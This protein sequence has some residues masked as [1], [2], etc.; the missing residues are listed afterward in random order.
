MMAMRTP[1]VGFEEVAGLQ[2]ETVLNRKLVQRMGER[3]AFRYYRCRLGQKP[4][5]PLGSCKRLKTLEGN[6]HSRG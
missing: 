6:G 3:Q 2:G 4:F 1:S 5:K